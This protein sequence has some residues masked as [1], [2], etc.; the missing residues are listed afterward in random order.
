[1]Q[2]SL[3]RHWNCARQSYIAN[4]YFRQQFWSSHTVFVGEATL[5]A[6]QEVISHIMT[7]MLLWHACVWVVIMLSCIDWVDYY[8]GPVYSLCFHLFIPFIESFS[9]LR[10]TQRPWPPALASLF[11]SGNPCTWPVSLTHPIND[12]HNP[13]WLTFIL[14]D[15]MDT[16]WYLVIYSSTIYFCYMLHSV[17]CS[18]LS[19]WAQGIAMTPSTTISTL[20]LELSHSCL[21]PRCS[22]P[23]SQ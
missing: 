22:G 2:I 8:E 1:M 4:G 3:D 21:S 15:R 5:L 7:L 17:F 19:S 13:R 11:S 12:L 16:S 10:G 6:M 20:T 18:D 14:C 9:T 23:P